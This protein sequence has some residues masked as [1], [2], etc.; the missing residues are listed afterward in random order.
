MSS[1]PL[2]IELRPSRVLRIALTLLA[3]LACLALWRSAAPRVL[4]PV[5]LAM[6]VLAWPREALVGSTLVLRGD[7]TAGLLAPDASESEVDP[8][9]LQR[10]GALTVLSLQQDGLRRSLLFTPETLHR[11]KARE[12]GLWFDRHRALEPAYGG[13]SHV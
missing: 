11:A 8:R 2:R 13:D 6:L 7:G 3:A 5:P 9:I 4:L 12:L 10:R 1:P